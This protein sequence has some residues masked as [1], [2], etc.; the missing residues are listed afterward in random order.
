MAE[1]A[2]G[3][4][5]N[6]EIE[7]NQKKK[8]LGEMVSIGFYD[9]QKSMRW[10]NSKELENIDRKALFAGLRYSPSPDAALPA[11]VRLL[12]N[13]PQ[14]EQQIN[15]AEQNLPLFRLLGASEALG[16]FLLRRPEHLDVLTLDPE[17]PLVDEFP[18]TLLPET[19]HEYLT[20]FAPLDTHYRRELLQAVGADPV[21][22]NPIATMSGKDAYVVLRS[23]YRRHLCEIAMR[24]TC[25]KAPHE[26]VP[27]AGRMLSDLAAATLDAALAISRQEAGEKFATE[28]VA[29]VDLAVIGMGKCGARELNYISD[30]D[31]VYA[32]ERKQPT[33]LPDGVEPLDENTASNIG[34]ELVQ[35][36]ARAIMGPAPEPMLWEVDA[37]LRPEGKD[38]ALVRTIDSFS[39]YYKRWAE[40]WEFQA[41]LKARP[42]AG[43]AELG[44]RWMK[45][46]H[47]MVW[48]SAA[49]DGFVESVQAMRARVTDNI[50]KSEVDRQI[51]LG[52]GGLRDV[53]FTVQLLQLVHGRTDPKVRTQS[54]IDSLNAL[55]DSSFISRADAAQFA[56]DYKYLRLLEHRIQLQFMRRTHLMP[57]KEA[58][59]RV[60]ARSVVPMDE[61]GHLAVDS[62]LKAWNRIKRHVRSL[63]E[64]LFFRPL[65]A[66]V[67]NLSKDQLALTKEAAEDRLAALGYK[68]PRGSMRHIEALTRGIQRSA[69][70]Q[71][72]LMP[73]LLGWFAQGVD[74]DAGLLGFRRIS[75]SLGTTP[76]YLRMLRD[77]PAAAERLCQILSSSR[78]IGDILEDAPES[79]TWLDKDSEL[80]PRSF[81]DLNTLVR[82]QLIRHPETV[83]AI[84]NL[85]MI[86]RREILRIAMGE[87]ANLLTVEDVSLG[88]SHIDQVTIE[89]AL[90]IAQRELY[91]EDEHEPL[92]DLCVVAMGRQG[93]CEI[94]YGSDADLIYVHHPR[95]GAD[96][97]DAVAEANQLIQRMIQ[98]L[99][100]PCKPAIRAEKVL[101]IDADLRPEGKSG[102]MVRSLDSYR[103]YYERWADTWEFQA[104]LRARPIAGSY[105]LGAAFTDLINRYRYPTRF[106]TAQIIEIRRMKARVENERMP[107]GADRTRQLKLGRGGLSD[108]EWVAQLLQLCKASEYPQLQVTGTITVLNEAENLGL[109]GESDVRTLRDAWML[110]TKIRG[111]NVLRTGR[112][113]DVL[114]AQRTD[115]EAIARWCGYA[116]G[117]ARDLEEDYLRVTRHARQVY[118]RLFF[119]TDLL[120][121]TAT[122]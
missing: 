69:E 60:L 78:F 30:V 13:N 45:A 100:Q 7:K 109:L 21:A 3:A 63:H 72:T 46:M 99:K 98:L 14:L 121:L 33:S 56:D 5:T 86:R 110:A 117:H 15:D 10:L 120:A 55:T 42:V 94:G 50:P 85:R 25:S 34:V 112:A 75:E 119:D 74:P 97:K 107:R 106:E 40:N 58:N 41:L 39:T 108:V 19:D 2:S 77:S 23:H 70:I 43:N 91:I 84:R 82:N 68:D 26:F 38:G 64:Q 48:E 1:P 6:A 103:E 53:E 16:D 28:D 105:E 8:M 92:T 104:L 102:P 87:A 116:P 24:D 83:S 54:T 93:G 11:L 49:R 122:S 37:N 31:V 18:R 71:R 90:Q 32:C 111:C 4:H 115:L 65:L 79:I 88:L 96:E 113:S 9:A 22:E 27:T 36:L 44:Y 73:V 62:L 47:P 12:T 67:S 80:K 29:Q 57:D 66:A 17:S 95:V 114:T 61:I 51:K 35:G 89:G 81:D 76:W 52:P 20:P 101:E 118:E 59:Q